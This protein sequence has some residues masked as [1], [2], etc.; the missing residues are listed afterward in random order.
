MEATDYKNVHRLKGKLFYN[1]LLDVISYSYIL[2]FFYTAISKIITYSTF[3]KVLSDLPLIGGYYEYVAFG[4]ILSEMVIGTMLIIPKWRVAGINAALLLMV[5]F[6]IYLGY[7]ILTR[8]KLPCS[9]GGVISGMTWHQH[10][11]FNTGFIFLA[12]TGLYINKIFK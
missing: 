4:I 6:T 7:H 1:A 2:L 8:S 5:V 10:L 11:A 9:C 3:R 12:I